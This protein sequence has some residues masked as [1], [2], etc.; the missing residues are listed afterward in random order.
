MVEE[1][2]CAMMFDNQFYVKY[3]AYITEDLFS[4][5]ITKQLYNY[6]RDIVG[7]GSQMTKEQLQT[8]VSLPAMFKEYSQRIARMVINPFIRDNAAAYIKQSMMLKQATDMMSSI[9]NWSPNDVGAHLDNLQRTFLSDYNQSEGLDMSDKNIADKLYDYLTMQHTKVSSGNDGFDMAMGGGWMRQSMNCF[10]AS[11][12]KGKTI[13]LV[14]QAWKMAKLGYNV[15]YFTLE[16]SEMHVIS[17]IFQNEQGVDFSNLSKSNV[18]DI[19]RTAQKFQSGGCSLQVFELSQGAKSSSIC[20]V[21]DRLIVENNWKPDAIIVDYLG[22]M[23]SDGYNGKSDNSY[24]KFKMVSEEL[25]NVMKKYDCVGIT[26]AQMNRMAND[27]PVADLQHLRESIGV[28]DIMN[29]VIMIDEP[30]GYSEHNYQA[31]T[32]RKNRMGKQNLQLIMQV[33]KGLNRVVYTTHSL[34]Y[35]GQVW[36]PQGVGDFD[37]NTMI[38]RAGGDSPFLQKVN[39]AND[40]IENMSGIMRGGGQFGC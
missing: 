3:H 25:K 16:L 31:L 34:I 39:G 33:D 10:C 24:Y 23:G 4:D 12:G 22:L 35:N 20:A 40:T 8:I 37:V 26:A 11:T 29:A 28:H 14:D 2:V 17:R 15:L 19:K 6:I 13:H 1:Q 38:D 30:A 7:S 18:D 27:V 5:A 36:T 21:V 9:Q 32:F